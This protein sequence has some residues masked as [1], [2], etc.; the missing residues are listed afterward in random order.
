MT[1]VQKISIT[2]QKITLI[3]KPIIV[4]VAAPDGV[5]V[6]ALFFSSHLALS[7]VLLTVSENEC[8]SLDIFAAP[9]VQFCQIDTIYFRVMCMN[10]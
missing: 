3:G 6:H 4:P 7:W 1:L 10:T 2:K 5:K 9:A 8:N